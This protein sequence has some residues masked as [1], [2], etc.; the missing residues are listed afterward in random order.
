MSMEVALLSFADLLEVADLCAPKR[1]YELQSEL[2]EQCRSLRRAFVAKM[3]ERHLFRCE[4]CGLQTG[5][6]LMHFEDP[7]QPLQT[8]ANRLMWGTPVGHYVDIYKSALHQVLVHG[9]DVPPALQTLLR[10][11][12]S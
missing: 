4:T 7:K 2:V 11:V 1:D 12:A 6:V 5:E 8:E 3:P 9:A 10:Q